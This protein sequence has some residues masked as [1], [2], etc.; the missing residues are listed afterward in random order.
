MDNLCKGH[1]RSWLET[2][3]EKLKKVVERAFKYKTNFV[4]RFGET[5]LRQAS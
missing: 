5:M 2:T 3:K 1:R 4:S